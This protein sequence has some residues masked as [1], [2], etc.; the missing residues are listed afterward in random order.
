MARIILHIGAGKCGSSA[1]QT[2]LTRNPVLT[3]RDG[4]RWS[5]A[6]FDD[7]LALSAG[8]GLRA[9]PVRGYLSCASLANLRPHGPAE[10]ARLARD[11]EA[12]GPVILSNEALLCMPD[13]ARDFLEALG[14]PVTIVAYVRPQVDYVNSA[15][16]QWG[17][18]VCGGDALD[19]DRWIAKRI[20]QAQYCDFLVRW[21]SIGVVDRIVVR[22]LPGDV[23]TDFLDT[24]GFERP[25]GMVTHRAN[26]SLPGPVLRLLQACP[27][28][29]AAHGPEIDFLLPALLPPRA[30]GP[31]PWVIDRQL[32]QAIIDRSR[33]GNDRLLSL[34]TPDC[35]GTLR[36]DPRW[37][38]A[39]SFR[40]RKVEPFHAPLTPE[41]ALPLACDLLTALLALRQRASKL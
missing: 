24:L 25:E 18:W 27:E 32:A 2:H 20:R 29:R 15:W 34:M 35:A 30:A 26:P 1:L 31:A 41:A 39:A 37:W 11:L 28:L 17:A 21:Q 5:Y 6:V 12:G 33:P 19:R 22:P 13:L 40:D 9:D 38:D 4:S 14:L 23:V 10:L 16:W 8:P 3:H 36:E 7:R